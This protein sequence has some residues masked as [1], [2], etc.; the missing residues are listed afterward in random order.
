MRP[1]ILTTAKIYRLNTFNKMN[2]PYKIDS[3]IHG[4][5]NSLASELLAFYTKRD[6]LAIR[7]L[8]PF[9]IDRKNTF[10]RNVIKSWINIARHLNHRRK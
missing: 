1:H 9:F 10:R 6:F 3:S 7:F 8:C 2:L 4:N 5:L